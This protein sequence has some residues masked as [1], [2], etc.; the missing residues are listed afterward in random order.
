MGER[1]IK[2]INVDVYRVGPPSSTV[3]SW[4][5]KDSVIPLCRYEMSVYRGESPEEMEL[6]ASGIKADLFD[7]FEDNTAR[8]MSKHRTYYYRVEAKNTSTGSIVESEKI[9][10]EGNLDLVGMYVIEEHDFLF[11][12]VTG[13]PTVIF[14]KQTDG[15]TRCTDCWDTV[16]KRVT[17]SSCNSCHGTGF[18]GRGVGGFYNPTITWCDFSPDPE[19][20]QITQWGK[21]EST[22]TDIFMSN[23]PRISVG[24]IIIEVLTNKRWKVSNVRDSEKR[25]VKMLQIVRVDMINKDQTEYKIDI[26]KEIMETARQQLKE[27]KDEREF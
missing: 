9:T 25:R 16:L 3:V 17:K 12:H 20:I 18:I 4:E 19:V 10:P 7:Q 1:I 22:Q 14:K 23:Y 6:I 2:S 5:W 26:P 13:V 21:V 8:L 27:S 11:R 15:E 24:D